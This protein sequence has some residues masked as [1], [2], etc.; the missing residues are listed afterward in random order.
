[1]SLDDFRIVKGQ[2][3]GQGNYTLAD[4]K[5]VPFSVFI[6]P[7]FSRVG[8]SETEAKAAGHNVKVLSLPAAAIPKAQVLRHP[9]GVLKAVVDADTEEN[10]RRHAAVRRI[11]R[12]DQCRQAGHGHGRRLHRAP[13]PD[14]YAS[15]HERSAE[16]SVQSVKKLKPGAA[17]LL[18][19]CPGI[20][21]EVSV[22]SSQAGLV[23]LK[24]RFA[25][26]CGP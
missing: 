5:N 23:Q 2:L 1:V 7:P 25:N 17:A 8:L 10:L 26:Y 21:M 11:L 13:G 6:D 3:E 15:D 4:R 14:F 12:D 18:L 24:S 20:G 19:S 9:A 16:R 22:S